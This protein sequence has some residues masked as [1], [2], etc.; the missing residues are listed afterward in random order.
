MVYCVCVCARAHSLM[1][2]F[3]AGTM[4]LSVLDCDGEQQQGATVKHYRIRHLDPGG[5]FITTRKRFH[6]LAHLIQHYRQSVD[7]L[8]CLLGAP[9]SRPV[10]LIHDLSY[11]T[12]DH[13]EIPRSSI[14]LQRQLG[15]G[16]FGEVW[17]GKQ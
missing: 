3:C 13:W 8:C 7:G 15:A 10:P 14:V 17:K 2:T 11:R 4:S 9:C 16:Q 1:E 12:K 5:F 6:S